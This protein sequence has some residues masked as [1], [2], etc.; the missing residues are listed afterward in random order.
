MGHTQKA[1]LLLTC[2]DCSGE[3][4]PGDYC[5]LSQKLFFFFFFHETSFLL[6]GMMNKPRTFTFGCGI[7]IF[8]KITEANLRLQG[9]QLEECAANPEI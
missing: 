2:D 7:D 9:K 3:G 6:K 1:L 4:H 8:F 5:E